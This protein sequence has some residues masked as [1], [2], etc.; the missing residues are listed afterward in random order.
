MLSLTSL[1][2]N[3]GSL[4]VWRPQS[5]PSETSHVCCAPSLT[6]ALLLFFTFWGECSLA[7]F[8]GHLMLQRAPACC[9]LP[10]SL[11]G[12][13]NS[14]SVP[15]PLLS[16]EPEESDAVDVLSNANSLLCEDSGGSLLFLQ[17]VWGLP[18]FPADCHPICS[19][20]SDSFLPC[21]PSSFPECWLPDKHILAAPVPRS[22]KQPIL[23]GL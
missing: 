11:S 6:L 9:L 10:R 8:R 21:S 3:K 19:Q 12:T 13:R 20:H 17:G 4:T 18:S 5:K 15:P 2:R 7:P 1:P 22:R 16:L 14:I 23:W